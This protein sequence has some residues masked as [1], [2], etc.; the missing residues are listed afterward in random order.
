MRPIQQKTVINIRKVYVT[1]YADKYLEWATNQ[2]LFGL[3]L[4]IY[5]VFA[6][7]IG[8]VIIDN[9]QMIIFNTIP[10]MHLTQSRV[11]FYLYKQYVENH[12]IIITRLQ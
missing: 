2:R 7:S 11:L 3:I 4:F 12:I 1:I 5:S 9:I 8:D 10:N 6:C